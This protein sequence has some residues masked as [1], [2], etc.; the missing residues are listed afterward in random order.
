MKILT[1]PV[2]MGSGM[3]HPRFIDEQGLNLDLFTGPHPPTPHN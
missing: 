2:K 3:T 1:R